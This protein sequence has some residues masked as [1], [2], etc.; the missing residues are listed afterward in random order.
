MRCRK[1]WVM[2][3]SVGYMCTGEDGAVGVLC[4]KCSDFD[5][6]RILEASNKLVGKSAEP[7]SK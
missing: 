7:I 3:D 4:K 5:R 6:Q 1:P 2:G